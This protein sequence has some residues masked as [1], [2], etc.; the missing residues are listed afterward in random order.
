MLWIDPE[1]NVLDSM[2]SLFV[3]GLTG[4][5]LKQEAVGL[6]QAAGIEPDPWQGAVLRSSAPQVILLCSRQSGKSTVSALLA[7]H[8]AVVN[9][10]ALV[11]L[12]APTLRQSQELFR[13]VR[14]LI[15]LTGTMPARET[16][17]SLE[18]SSGSRIVCL[19]GTEATIRGYSNVALLVVDEAARVRDDLYQAVRPMLAVSGGRLVLLSTPFGQRGFFHHEWTNGGAGWQ[20]VKVTASQCPR[21]APEWLAEERDRIGEWWFRQE[22]GCEFV[23]TV[24]QVF[25]T[26]D[27]L[28]ALSDDIEP[29]FEEVA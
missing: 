17:L 7:V 4:V 28:R 23:D 19:P 6:A 21:I 20:R 16:S 25:P 13:K 18:F 9:A 10:P 26:E 29:L 8:E 15:P 12:L 1:R 14:E 27:V 22:Y 24:D 11:L 5:G 3:R 2:R